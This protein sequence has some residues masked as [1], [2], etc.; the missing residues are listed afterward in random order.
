MTTNGWLQ[1]ALLFGL[2]LLTARPLGIFTANVLDGKTGALDRIF[3]PAERAF[4]RLLGPTALREQDWR[5]Y[6]AAVLV[7]SVVGFA[8]LYAIQRLQAF[9]PFNPAGQSAVSPDLAFNTAIS[10][11]TNTNWQS[12][13]G[14][15]TMSHFTQMVGF[16]VQN[17][18][19]AATGIALA[20]AVTRAFA[21]SESK[22]L[23]NFWVDLTRT[24]IYVL[25]PL[26]IIVALAFAALGMPQTLQGSV[27][28]TTLEGT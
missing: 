15:T 14:E 21:R 8:L 1:I 12:Y 11:V 9:L 3:G 23:G 25:L 18:L 16:T 4:Y 7:F 17:F 6:A 19:S 24:T 22:T 20:V 5:A 10:F 13:G 27:D 28:A 2:V 26:S